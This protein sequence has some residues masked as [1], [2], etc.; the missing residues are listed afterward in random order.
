MKRVPPTGSSAVVSV[1]LFLMWLAIGA[2]KWVLW[3]LGTL[4]GTSVVVETMRMVVTRR[5]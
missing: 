5:L 1:G 3:T 4:A 2:P